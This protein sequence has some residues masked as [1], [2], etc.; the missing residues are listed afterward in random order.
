[1]FNVAEGNKWE[2]ARLE[3]SDWFELT[4]YSPYGIIT[5][6]LKGYHERGLA[7][8]IMAVYA[9]LKAQGPIKVEAE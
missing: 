9:E 1:M 7:L 8:S 3:D 2:L 5:V 4:L 6:K